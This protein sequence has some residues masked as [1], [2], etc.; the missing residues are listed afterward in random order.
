MSALASLERFVEEGLVFINWR[1]VQ[2]LFTKRM[3]FKTFFFFPF[4]SW[5]FSTDWLYVELWLVEL[6]CYNVRDAHWLPSIL[7][8][9]TLR[10]PSQDHELEGNSGIPTRG[11]HF[12]IS[13][14]DN[15]KVKSVHFLKEQ[16]FRDPQFTQNYDHFQY[17][18]SWIK[19]KSADAYFIIILSELRIAQL[20]S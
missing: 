17:Y 12:R 8:R 16:Q 19:T 6:G 13:E 7:L 18:I 1:Y 2:T 14:R 20:C 5:S 15:Q 10:N 9:N 11:A 3:A 4:S